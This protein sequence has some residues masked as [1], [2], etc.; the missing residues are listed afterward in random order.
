MVDVRNVFRDFIGN[1]DKKYKIVVFCWWHDLSTKDK[2]RSIVIPNSKYK[3]LNKAEKLGFKSEYIVCTAKSE[4][5]SWGFELLC[6]GFSPYFRYSRSL[7]YQK[8]CFL[9]LLCKAYGSNRNFTVI[10]NMWFC[11][12]SILYLGENSMVTGQDYVY[13][14]LG[15]PQFLAKISIL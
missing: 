11:C 15:I 6:F 5:I 9:C 14:L 8:I 2:L 12:S 3:T 4:N 7:K 13:I 10:S 1:I